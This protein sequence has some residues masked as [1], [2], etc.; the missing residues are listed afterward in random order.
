MNFL[1]HTHPTIPTPTQACERRRMV[2]E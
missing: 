1:S 2:V